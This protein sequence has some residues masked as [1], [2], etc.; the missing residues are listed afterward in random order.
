M[1][2]KSVVGKSLFTFKTPKGAT[3]APQLPS[4]VKK[5]SVEEQE[6]EVSELSSLDG[7]ELP[8][9]KF[10][11]SQP[12]NT[13][14]KPSTTSFKPKIVK[15][16]D[17]NDQ[18][19]EVPIEVPKAV[20]ISAPKE[21]KPLP[22]VSKSTS[23]RQMTF[24]DDD[25]DEDIFASDKKSPKE[26]QSLFNVKT[27]KNKLPAQEKKITELAKSKEPKSIKKEENI[28]VVSTPV[29]EIVKLGA[30]V[31]IDTNSVLLD[32]ER[33]RKD[34][35][36]DSMDCQQLI[37]EQLKFYK[38]FYDIHNQIPLTMYENI[39]GYDK[40]LVLKIKSMITSLNL[41]VKRKESS[42]Q[43]ASLVNGIKL[44][45]ISP[46]NDDQF[47][48]DEVM[49]EV[50]NEKQICNGKFNNNYVDL[51]SPS[52][53]SSAFQ[54]RIN[55]KNQTN[56]TQSANSS[57]TSNNADLDNDGFPTFD[58]SQLVDVLPSQSA[59]TSRQANRDSMDH[60]KTSENTQ[61]SDLNSSLIGI[62]HDNVPNDGITG[63]FDKTFSFSQEIQNKFKYTF[64]LHEFRQNQLQAINAGM[65][66]M[67]CFIL[68]PTGGGKSLCYQLPAVCCEGV[69]IVVSPLKSLIFDQVNK[70]NTL[71]VS[72]T[73]K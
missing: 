73:F 48:V 63:Q 14:I 52:T 24:L 64:G 45:N 16:K 39:D 67:D 61:T 12:P 55:M 27:L 53:S 30:S 22:V 57:Y 1:S 13:I 44:K 34:N 5:S 25:E 62:F 65:L 66:N 42:N 71:D 54:P 60:M 19:K 43:I 29:E 58:Y 18:P 41:R 8:S 28:T 50:Q 9:Y 46:K 56:F 38:H 4:D 20:K 35:K 36:M 10:L 59:S 15:S 72:L 17:T 21:T 23:F 37:N 32:Y 68:M 47:D 49:Q 51:S 40:A 31:K 2:S 6:D 69:S 7:Y 11:C 33:L 70:L 3:P 26:T